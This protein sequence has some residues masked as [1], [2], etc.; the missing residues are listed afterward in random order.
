MV[1]N[2]EREIFESSAK[3][4]EYP[5]GIA[6]ARI[7]DDLKNCLVNHAIMFRIYKLDNL[8]GSQAPNRLRI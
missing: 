6:V 3:T 7:A 5:E 4:L 8:A 2:N 1:T